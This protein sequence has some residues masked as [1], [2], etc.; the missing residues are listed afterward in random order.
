MLIQGSFKNING[1]TISVKIYNS[2]NSYQS[3]TIGNDNSADVY[4]AGEEPI[5]VSVE[6]CDTL[7][8][9]MRYSARINLIS[10]IYLGD[11]L[12]SA[13]P[14]ATV[15]NIYKNGAIVFA[16]YLQHNT[17]SQEYAYTWSEI[18]LNCI[19]V[20]S[21]LEYRYL[22]DASDYDTVKANS[23]IKSFYDIIHGFDIENTK[24]DLSLVQDATVVGAPPIAQV[25]RSKIYFDNSKKLVTDGALFNEVGINDSI[26]LGDIDSDEEN[27]LDILTALLQ[28]LNLHIVQIGLHF[29][30]YDIETC[31]TD[32]S[33]VWYNLAD[34]T[35]TKTQTVTSHTVT[36]DYY[37][38]DDTNIDTA[39]VYSRVEVHEKPDALDAIVSNILDDDELTSPYSNKQLYCREYCSE[40]EGKNAWQAFKDMVTNG[41]STY[42]DKWTREWYMQVKQPKN[43]VFKKGDTDIYGSYVVSNNTLLPQTSLPSNMQSSG[44][45]SGI[46]AMGAAEKTDPSNDEPNSNLSMTNSLYISINGNGSAGE[47]SCRPNDSDFE[48]ANLEIKYTAPV[49]ANFTPVDAGTINYIVVS[50]KIRLNPLAQ[51]TGLQPLMWVD[52]GGNATLQPAATVTN[53]FQSARNWVTNWEYD[54]EFSDNET[55]VSGVSKFYQSK[56]NTCPISSNKKG[57]Y[58]QQRFYTAPLPSQT[59]TANDNTVM[60]SPP[61]DFGSKDDYDSGWLQFGKMYHY[62]LTGNNNPQCGTDTISKVPILMCKLKVGDKYFCEWVDDIDHLEHREWRDENHLPRKFY[63]SQYHTI[64]YFTIGFNP[65]GDDWII[66]EQHNI[67]NTITNQMNLGNLSGTAIPITYDKAVNGKLEFSICGVCNPWWDD[68]IRIHPTWF[69]HTKWSTNAVPVMPFVSSIILDNFEVHV[70]SNNG[71]ASLDNSTEDEIVYMSDEQMDYIKPLKSDFDIMS[72]LTTEDA[73]Q[74]GVVTSVNKNTAT[75]MTT[76][77]ALLTITDNHSNETAKAEHLYVD[78]V[79]NEYNSPK[80]EVSTSFFADYNITLFD[81]VSFPYFSGKEFFVKGISR[82]LKTDYN[83]FTFKEI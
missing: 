29:Y 55:G 3:F 44:F 69:R 24:L 64:D 58:Y 30:I 76:G 50:G 4:F 60:V 41:T 61:L 59:P 47:N 19:D 62:V 51:K 57:A 37:A 56:Y 83:T 28:Y 1:D 81:R 31:R 10:R 46:I 33:V 26:F 38:S 8:Q 82:N 54:D 11:A 35:D 72:A 66:G 18:T 32:T 74:L 68:Q 25:E 6:E 70:A 2:H 63:D 67:A 20:L 48:N 45:V 7:S 34:L 9:V 65:K 14:T 27:C 49:S 12:W 79:F 23:G 22:S 21:S 53:T 15:V 43:W 40:G 75:N 77:N 16:G 80:L 52:S 71:G 17:Y 39:D 13:N 78:S 73:R 42:A 36:A 5:V